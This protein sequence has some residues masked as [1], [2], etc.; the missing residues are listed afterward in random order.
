MKFGAVAKSE[1]VVELAAI[2]YDFIELTADELKAEA[3]AAEFAPVRVRILGSGLKAEAFNKF[4]P[5]DMMLVGPSVDWPR[6]E[7]FVNT[8][9]ARMAELGG[10]VMVWGSPHARNIPAGF[11]PE[12]AFEQLVRAGHLIADAAQRAGVLVVI[13]P[14]VHTS[15]NTIHKLADGLDLM[16]QINRPEITVMADIFHMDGNGEG[17]EAI[18][19][20]KG[21]LGHVHV[22][23]LDRKPP[24]SGEQYLPVYRHT[25]E[26]LREIGYAGRVSIETRWTDFGAEARRALATLQEAFR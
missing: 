22:S 2:G 13:E 11:P 23:D 24:G 12:A 8:C 18:R 14:L 20:L 3:A 19:A 17:P 6:V 16:R 5:G 15:T 10:E 4:I 25:N 9:L 1:R 7:A 26:I 21:V